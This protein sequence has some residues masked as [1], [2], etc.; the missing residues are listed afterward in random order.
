VGVRRLW[1][2]AL[3]LAAACLILYAPVAHFQFLNFDDEGY[4][5]RNSHV[6]AGLTR[7][8]I[9]WAFTTIDNFYWH[10]LTWLS[11]MLD[12]QFFGLNPGPPHVINALFHTL[13]AL[14]VFAV[15]YRLTN[16]LW[17]SAV[18]SAVFALHPLRIESVAWVAERKDLL[19]AFWF[20]VT[21]WCYLHYA[22]RPSRGRYYLT[23]S[24][25][26]LGLM[27]KPMAMTLPFILMLLDYW[28]LRRRAFT[29]K[30]PMIGL[31]AFSTLITSIGTARLGVINWGATIPLTS[32][33]A[34][35]LVSYV[36]YL[37]LA[38]WPHDLAV[39]YPFR[40][41][42]PLWQP[43]LACLLL[44]LI[45]LASLSRP[46]LTV[47]WFWWVIGILPAS[48]LVQVGR[49]GMADRFTYLPMIGLAMAVI[50]FVADLLGKRQ[51]VA[52]AG[53]ATAAISGF[54][55]ATIV[56][57]PV[58]RNS[59]TVFSQ[60]VAA[61]ENNSAAHHFLASALE[62][63]GRY[64]EAFP[65]RAEAVR[66]EPSYFVAQYSYGLALERRGQT[67]DAAEHFAQAVRYFPDYP[68]A[69]QHLDAALL[70]LGITPSY[71]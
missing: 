61:T 70:R 27:C 41:S 3:L 12:C 30:L 62:D 24:A 13:N 55:F 33:I 17:R 65:H 22:E 57:L 40:L 9:A 7:A 26:V 60:T 8:G 39:L 71:K 45:T 54:T 32:R 5:T 64:D 4:V 44:M 15:F 58:W 21:I 35:A 42:V 56:D 68:E 46:Y 51:R 18:L 29:E 63:Q 69:R 20:L 10:P 50:W 37:E 14:L 38:F 49:Q 34:N 28:P 2:I 31:A 53:L 47:G 52:A 67:R 16:A 6:Q 23:L 43:I 1:I 48:G 19:S 59:V 36:K 11:H 25:F 66:I